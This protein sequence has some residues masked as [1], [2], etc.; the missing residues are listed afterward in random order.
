MTRTAVAADEPERG[1][2]RLFRMST[3]YAAGTYST[4]WGSVSVPYVT[5]LPC[6]GAAPATTVTTWKA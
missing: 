5:A 2:L 4:V 6:P 3:N 1:S